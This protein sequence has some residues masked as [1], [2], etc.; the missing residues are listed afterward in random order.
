MVCNDQISFYSTHSLSII[1]VSEESS[2]NQG[3]PAIH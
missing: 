2:M 1:L 3:L